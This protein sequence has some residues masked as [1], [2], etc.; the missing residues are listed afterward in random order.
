MCVALLLLAVAGVAVAA[1]LPKTNSAVQGVV[2]GIASDRIAAILE[3]LES[4]ETRHTFSETNHPTRGIG[5]ARRWIFEE[6]AS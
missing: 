1:E 6:M 4:F 2:E 3:K 5:A